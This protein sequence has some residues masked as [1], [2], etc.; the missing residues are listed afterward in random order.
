MDLD[1]FVT[2]GGAI[3]TFGMGFMALVFPACDTEIIMYPRI[4]VDFDSINSIL[5]NC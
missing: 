1:I 3:F 2:T 5:Q 4:F